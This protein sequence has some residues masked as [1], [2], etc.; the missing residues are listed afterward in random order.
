MELLDE[1][2]GLHL[3]EHYEA[4]V[5]IRHG[6]PALKGRE[7]QPL[8]VDDAK[9]LL[10]FRRG[11]G[12]AEAV[13]VV[14][15]RDDDAS[16]TIPFPDGRWHELLFEYEIEAKRGTLSDTLPASAAKLYVRDTD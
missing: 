10:A 9:G 6:S 7:L 13:V 11:F 1:D 15:L 5:H 2:Y 8:H 14:N 12:D 3:K 16:F 4:L